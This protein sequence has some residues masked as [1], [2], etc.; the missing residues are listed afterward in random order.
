M[1]RDLEKMYYLFVEKES[2]KFFLSDFISAVVELRGEINDDLI[3]KAFYMIAGKLGEK[4][5]T[6]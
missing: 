1:I 2:G 4:Y 3:T 5:I 6:R